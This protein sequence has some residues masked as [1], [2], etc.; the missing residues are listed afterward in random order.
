M[1]VFS[2]LVTDTAIG[3]LGPLSSISRWEPCQA[4]HRSRLPVVN[5]VDYWLTSWDPWDGGEWFVIEAV[6]HV[7]SYRVQQR[8]AIE[9]QLRWKPARVLTSDGLSL[10]PFFQLAAAPQVPPAPG[11]VYEWFCDDCA[12][13][14][15][16]LT[17]HGQHCAT[18]RRLAVSRESWGELAVGA[19]AC[20]PHLLVR[21][22]V[23]DAL[24]TIKLKGVR[25]EAVDWV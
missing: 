10:L 13:T 4:C 25:Y 7:V 9:P 3:E 5:H 12:E 21:D 14:S 16:S 8:L 1:Q 18:A 19:H 22:D 2:V 20:W 17:S 11:L 15:L 24:S 6:S 23:A